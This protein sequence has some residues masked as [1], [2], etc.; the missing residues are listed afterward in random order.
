M[1][2]D[3]EAVRAFYNEHA[4]GEWN[5]IGG[6]PEFLLTC[7]FLDKL[8][9]AGSRVADIGGGPGR[10]SLHLAGRGCRVTLCDLSEENVRLA[11]KRAEAEGIPLAAVAGDAL[12]ITDLPGAPFDAVLFMGPLY[13]LL[14]EEERI[15]AVEN[16]LGMLE[17]GGLFFASFILTTADLIDVMKSDSRSLLEADPANTG[18][19]ASVAAG[20]G[21]TGDAFTRAYFA[22]V[23]EIMP[24]LA[25]FPLEPVMIFGQ[26]GI[27]SPCEER[28]MERSPEEIG[29]WLDL[30]EA[31]APRR[32]YWGFS[33]HLMFVGRKKGGETC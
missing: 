13:H 6:R 4:A 26:E 28:I 16:A 7:R 18:L 19:R 17:T 10:Y 5:R 32:E 27:M 24:F 22:D 21:Y 20:V 8:I 1:K 25:R 29:R 30:S 15:R 11:E 3:R 2:T 14:E 31:L 33:E 9:P 23:S 12:E